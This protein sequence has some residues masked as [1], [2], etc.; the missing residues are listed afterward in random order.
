MGLGFYPLEAL[1]EQTFTN[2]K[3]S[4]LKSLPVSALAASADDFFDHM[5]S[6]PKLPFISSNLWKYLHVLE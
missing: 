4:R 6:G 5:R 3:R 2:G 1:Q